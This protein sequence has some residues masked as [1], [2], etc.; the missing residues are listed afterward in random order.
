MR[1][2]LGGG[3]E[4]KRNFFWLLNCLALEMG[5]VGKCK[6]KVHTRIGHEGP[7]RE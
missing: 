6:G 4:R 5:P 1:D 2:C 3:E 7:E